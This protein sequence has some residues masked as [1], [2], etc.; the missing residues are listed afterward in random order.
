MLLAIFVLFSTAGRAVADPSSPGGGPTAAVTSSPA[1]KQVTAV[2]PTWKT[3]G[4]GGVDNVLT[5]P[6]VTGVEYLVNGVVTPTGEYGIYQ[7]GD[8]PTKLAVAARPLPGYVLGGRTSW[9]FD[10]QAPECVAPHIAVHCGGFTVTNKA[11]YDIGFAWQAP[12]A[13][14][15]EKYFPRIA[16]G[17]TVRITTKLAR[18]DYLYAPS[19]DGTL[20]SIAQLTVPQNCTTPTPSSTPPAPT[21]TPSAPSTSS[22]VTGPPIVTD[23]PSSA[24]GD[25]ASLLLGGA[26]CAVGMV[27]AGFG[28]RR[29]LR[30][31]R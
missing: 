31:R 14:A 27:L 24:A 25:N 20:F 19:D 13:S 11:T 28:L 8:N 6:G 4:C 1:G 17:A 30:L 23:G 26:A 10:A 29:R 21:T 7:F 12:G 3:V 15:P 5:I 22:T 16:P 9:S 2:A 18:G